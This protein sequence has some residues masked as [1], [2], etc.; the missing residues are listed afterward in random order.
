MGASARDDE[1]N[2][3]FVRLGNGVGRGL[4]GFIEAGALLESVLNSPAAATE[5]DDE[6][7]VRLVEEQGCVLKGIKAA[8]ALLNPSLMS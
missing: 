6:A 4:K 8:G 5:R 2:D 3:D 1:A 7:E